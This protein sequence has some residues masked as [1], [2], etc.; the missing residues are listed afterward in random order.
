[1][2]SQHWLIIQSNSGEVVKGLLLPIHGEVA[3]R[4][5]GTPNFVCDLGGRAPEPAHAARPRRDRP[6]LRAA[7]RHRQP[8][9]R[10]QRVRSPFHPHVSRHVWRDAAPLPPAPPGGAGDVPLA[11]YGAQHHRHLPRRRLQQPRHVQPDFQRNR[12][13]EPDGLPR[14]GHGDQRSDL[15]HDV[16]DET[17]QFWRSGFQERLIASSSTSDSKEEQAML[18]SI[19]ISHIFVFDQ[20]QA[21]DF[22]V[23]KL[24]LEV[25]HDL[26]LGVMRWLTVRVP[27]DPTRDILLELPGP[28]GMDPKAGEQ[29][30]ELVSKGASGF[31]VG[32]TTSNAKKTYEG[33]KAKGVEI[34]DDLTERDYGTDFGIRDPFGNHIRIVQLAA[35][36]P[37]LGP[38][39]AAAEKRS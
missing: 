35:T 29:V 27:G 17:E 37:Q 5:G 6:R 23:A 39:T 24:G 26:D 13:P 22:Y 28:P 18:N 20:D 25:S 15:L 34:A 30:R 8:G 31:A 1:M 21:V 12:R 16:V 11:R 14:P 32:F 38:K 2:L 4:A 36:S 9:R 19:N 7:A 33:L 3:R 10:G